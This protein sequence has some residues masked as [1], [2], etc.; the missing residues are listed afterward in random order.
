VEKRE[1]LGLDSHK[2]AWHQD[3]IR[4]YLEKGDCFPIEAEIG[5]T[6]FCNHKCIFCALDWINGGKQFISPEVMC[7]SL[8][9]MADNG[10]K[11][12]VFAGEGEPLAHKDISLFV[13]T[14]K[15]SGLDVAM[16]TNAVL[17]NSRK[18]E[19][20]LPYLTWI[21]ASIDSGCS[22]NYAAIHGCAESDFGLLLQ[23][24]RYAVEFKKRN[25]L[26]VTIG[27]QFLMIP[28]NRGEISKL[29][30]I[31][32][33]IGVDNFQLKPYSHHPN[34]PDEFV[35]PTEIYEETERELNPLYGGNLDIIY[36]KGSV[37]RLALPRNYYSCLG[38][39]FFILATCY[40]DIIPCNLF[41]NQ[42]EFSFGNLNLQ[43]FQE[44]WK[45]DKRKQVISRL[46]KMGV[47]DCRPCCRQDSMNRWLADLQAGKIKLGYPQGNEPMH[48]NFI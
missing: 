27:T 9:D 23:N 2:L 34:R 30:K 41:Y 46:N 15:E 43:S 20:C 4:E 12:V 14:A 47:E 24:L 17:L 18:V 36:R 26:D 22:Q 10:L 13:R 1:R 40:G 33:E 42:E 39:P 35:V 25:N 29:A 7:N 8:K 28:Q 3:R 37:E 48:I 19:Q 6:N 38:H 32:E 11:S 16:M 31:L 44:I 21:R 45:G 5:V